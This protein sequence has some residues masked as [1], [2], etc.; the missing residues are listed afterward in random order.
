ML[1][2]TG[3]LEAGLAVVCRGQIETLR[4]HVLG[5]HIR[6]TAVI[7]DHQYPVSRHRKSS[8]RTGL[9]SASERILM[10]QASEKFRSSGGQLSCVEQ[11]NIIS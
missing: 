9:Q 3:S 10:P 2:C 6:E 5:E 11:L 1:A 4:G 7:I 8:C